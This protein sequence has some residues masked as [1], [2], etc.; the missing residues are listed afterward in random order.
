MSKS[1]IDVPVFIKKTENYL[2]NHNKFDPDQIKYNTTSL[3]GY[4]NELIPYEGKTPFDRM[5]QDFIQSENPQKRKP[6]LRKLESFIIE[7][8][9]SDD[10]DPTKIKS[11]AKMIDKFPEKCIPINS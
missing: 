6:K 2:K 7:D 10:S 3:H 9:S 4:M 5:V 8:D 1:V 11:M